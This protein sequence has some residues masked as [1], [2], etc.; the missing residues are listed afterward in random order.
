MEKVF[1]QVQE[2]YYC[3]SLSGSWLLLRLHIRNRL[4]LL[5]G[6]DIPLYVSGEG[7]WAHSSAFKWICI[8]PLAEAGS[9]R[10]QW[11]LVPHRAMAN[12]WRKVPAAAARFLQR[13]LL[14]SGGFILC[15]Q[16]RGSMVSLEVCEA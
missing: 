6:L 14:D 3:C 13:E 5:C 1:D 4:F 15:F 10:Q 2:A 16:K 9:R 11:W 12:L 8:P 7:L